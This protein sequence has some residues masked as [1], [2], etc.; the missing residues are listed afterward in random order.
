MKK[1][2]KEITHEIKSVFLVVRLQK[3]RIKEG[4]NLLIHQYYAP[5]YY[6]HRDASTTLKL[7]Q[8]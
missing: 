1:Y 5:K 3:P 6:L 4:K 2:D 7:D 8:A